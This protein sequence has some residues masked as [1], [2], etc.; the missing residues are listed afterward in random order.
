MCLISWE[1]TQKRDPHN[2]FGDI[3]G[4]KRGAKLAILGDKKF[5]LLFFLS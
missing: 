1:K 4:S 2:F 5:S 3:L